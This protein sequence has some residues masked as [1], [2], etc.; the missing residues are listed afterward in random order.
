MELTKNKPSLAEDSA[1]GFSYTLRQLQESSTYGLFCEKVYGRNLRQFNAVDEEQ[2]QKLLSSLN[3][4]ESHSLL[5]LGC[6]SGFISEYIS[7]VTGAKVTGIDF[8]EEIIESALNR[9]HLKRDRLNFLTADLNAIPQTLNK[10]NFIISVDTLYFA[11]ELAESIKAIKNL[12]MPGGQFAA[13]FTFKKKIGD[14]EN[15]LN[16]ETNKLGKALTNA[17]FNFQTYDFSSNEKVIWENTKKI[18][19]IFKESFIA[20]GYR[21]IYEERTWESERNLKSIYEDRSARSLYLTERLKY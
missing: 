11:S 13:F 21:E 16:P 1:Y 17:R 10:F 9:T 3:L 14:S 6:G 19:E 5:D 12:L 18:A 15:K 2:L 4:N 7:D 8:A 20:E